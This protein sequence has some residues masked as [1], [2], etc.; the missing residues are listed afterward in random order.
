MK[1][2]EKRITVMKSFVERARENKY[3]ESMIMNI[4]IICGS[5]QMAEHGYSTTEAFEIA[6][7]CVDKC[8]NE[9][10]TFCEL[11]KLTGYEN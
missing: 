8:K 11:L 10:E 3:T 5:S 2:R 1:E 6:T 4:G 9:M 7:K